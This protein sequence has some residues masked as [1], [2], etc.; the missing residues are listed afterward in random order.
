MYGISSSVSFVKGY[1]KSFL[2]NF[3]NLDIF[4]INNSEAGELIKLIKQRFF[5]E[6][7]ISSDLISFLKEYRMIYKINSKITQQFPPKKIEYNSKHLIEYLVL[8]HKD[9]LT[10]QK[11]LKICS[12]FKI[13]HLVIVTN[14]DLTK[15]VNSF[16]INN[17]YPE[18]VSIVSDNVKIY[19]QENKFRI[20][21]IKKDTKPFVHIDSMEL[22]SSL[23]LESQFSHNYFNK[24][25]F[26]D[27][28]G[29][30]KNS[31]NSDISF[32]NIYSYHITKVI[33]KAIF[34]PNFKKYWKVKK[35]ICAI[36]KDCEFRYMCVDDRIPYQKNKHEWFHKTAC[37]YDPYTATWKELNN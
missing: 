9:D 32:G 21:Y 8:E 14:N 6:E 36:C 2:I 29:N 18:S 35:D 13:P 16:L 28:N 25:I 34:N 26:I 31:P 19:A 4:H 37:N 15:K 11:A 17:S 23:F 3:K 7:E 5:K 30:I 20:L 1:R 27:E 12:F 24:K 10:V 33:K 22:N